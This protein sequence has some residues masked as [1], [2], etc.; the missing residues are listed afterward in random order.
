MED[1]LTGFE[2]AAEKASGL[3]DLVSLSQQNQLSESLHP[4]RPRPRA[5]VPQRILY[6]SIAIKTKLVSV[7]KNPEHY[8][9]SFF[10]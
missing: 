5:Q 6:S 1:V 2:D 3:E 9:Q 4:S 8:L 7:K 10:F